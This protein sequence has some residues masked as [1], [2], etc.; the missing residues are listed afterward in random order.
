M[1]GILEVGPSGWHSGSRSECEIIPGYSRGRG[2]GRILQ[3]SVP[4]QDKTW[5]TSAES[6]G[7]LSGEVTKPEEGKASEGGREPK[8]EYISRV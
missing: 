5:L 4:R 2:W 3:H 6:R 1:A 8:E 7:N